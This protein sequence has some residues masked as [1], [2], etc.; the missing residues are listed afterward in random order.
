M[1]Q[2]MPRLASVLLVV[3]MVWAVLPGFGTAEEP[4]TP[5]DLNGGTKA[6]TE[7]PVEET[8]PALNM[9]ASSANAALTAASEKIKVTLSGTIYRDTNATA[10]TDGGINEGTAAITGLTEEDRQYLWYTLKDFKL[11]GTVGGQEYDLLTD[12]WP[13]DAK[14]AQVTR[15][16]QDQASKYEIELPTNLWVVYRTE[17]TDSTVCIDD[18]YVGEEPSKPSVINPGSS[19]RKITYLYQ[20]FES[21][22]QSSTPPTTPGRYY[23]CANLERYHEYMFQTI[24]AGFYVKT[25]WLIKMDCPIQVNSGENIDVKVTLTRDDGSDATIPAG[26]YMMLTLSAL[27][28]NKISQKL[29]YNESAG[30]FVGAISTVGVNTHNRVSVWAEYYDADGTWNAK[31]DEYKV[32][33]NEKKRISERLSCTVQQGTYNG[34]KDPSGAEIVI[35]MS[36]GENLALNRDVDIIITKDREAYTP[37]DGEMTTDVNRIRFTPHLSGV[38]DME[39]V[40]KDTN[41]YYKGTFVLTNTCGV[42]EKTLTIAMQPTTV[43]QG[44]PLEPSYLANVARGDMIESM[45]YHFTTSDTYAVDELSKLPVGDNLYSYKRDSVKISSENGTDVTDCYFIPTGSFANLTVVPEASFTVT[46]PAAVELANG[47][48][49]MTLDCKIKGRTT[50]A[51]TAASANDWALKDGD[52]SIPYTLT[53]EASTARAAMGDALATFTESGTADLVFAIIGDRN[54]AA[55]TYTDTLTFTVSAAN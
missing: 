25:H 7:E 49:S 38:Y 55:G 5:T 10:S 18:W 48:G 2:W 41:P 24:F 33:V 1:K 43:I 44:Q 42:A 51:V 27:D 47:T 15:I 40:A 28:Q 4:A 22:S 19:E 39:I 20:P 11:M 45:E 30:G 35:N 37:M 21:V 34:L 3:M 17:E 23:I 6:P 8:P 26:S 53:P 31:S 46:I 9:A 36:E 50:V 14:R 54:P 12:S 29:L 32:Q 13:T 52:L 16:E